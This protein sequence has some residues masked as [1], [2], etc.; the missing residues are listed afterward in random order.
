MHH[1]T[2][3]LRSLCL[4]LALLFLGSATCGEKK[5]PSLAATNEKDAGPDFAIQGEYVGEVELA[6]GDKHQVGAQ[7]IAL[8]QGKFRIKFHLGGLPGAGFN[9]KI[10]RL[11]DAE[12]KDGK[13][14]ISGKLTDPVEKPESKDIKGAIADGVLTTEVDGRTSSFKRLVRTSPTLGAKPPEGAIVLFDGTNADEWKGGK[15][16]EG[17]LLNN[18]VYSK[19]SFKDFKAHLEFRLAFMPM[20]AAKGGPTA[21]FIRKD[22][23]TKCKSSTASALTARTMNAE[24]C[25]PCDRPT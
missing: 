10:I 6:G 25:T 23:I 15:L 4:V 7:V 8:G 18:G 16:V 3:A 1:E 21:A 24:P 20:P 5:K 14:V 2:N 22:T 13:T 12:T 11:A 19:R 9:G 17:N